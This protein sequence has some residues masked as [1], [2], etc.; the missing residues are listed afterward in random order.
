MMS[1]VGKK[2]V[3]VLFTIR[4]ICNKIPLYNK[5]LKSTEFEIHLLLYTISN[6][7]FNVPIN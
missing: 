7:N 1:H 2:N 4:V 5:P 6:A 3:F